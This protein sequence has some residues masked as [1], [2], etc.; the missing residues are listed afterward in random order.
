MDAFQTT[1]ALDL[2]RRP[3]ATTPATDALSRSLLPA[4]W[5]ASVV[6][7]DDVLVTR[8]QLQTVHR[9]VRPARTGSRRASTSTVER[10]S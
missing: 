3:G 2:G 8:W 5:N 7:R 4:S 6:L 9:P 10:A 1:S